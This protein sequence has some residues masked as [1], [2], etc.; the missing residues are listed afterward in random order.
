MQ[1]NHTYFNYCQNSIIGVWVCFYLKV[2]SVITLYGIFGSPCRAVRAV[3]VYHMQPQRR[4][5]SLML[6]YFARA[7]LCDISKQRSVIFSESWKHWE[8]KWCLLDPV[9][10]ATLVLSEVG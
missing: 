1:S 5:P 9:Y 2:L 7:L 10:Y 3:L 6:F 4:S 8:Y